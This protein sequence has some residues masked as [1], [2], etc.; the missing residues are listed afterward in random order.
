MAEKQK[1]GE[2]L[3]GTSTKGPVIK[4]SVNTLALWSIP[5]MITADLVSSASCRTVFLSST[6]RGRS[7]RGTEVS[8]TSGLDHASIPAPPN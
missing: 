2:N 1:G 5:Y 3:Q 4:E 6:P 7:R 8:M